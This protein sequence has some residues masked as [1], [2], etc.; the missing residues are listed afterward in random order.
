[1][2]RDDVLALV[3]GERALVLGASVSGL[4]AARAL[5]AL[6]A[7]VVLADDSDEVRNRLR[8][9]G[10]RVVRPEDVAGSRFAL[11]VVSPGIRPARV[12]ALGLKGP[13]VGELELGYRLTTTPITAVTGTNGK[14]TVATLT[15][16]MLGSG[17]RAVGNLGTALCDVATEPLSRLVVEVSSFQLVWTETFRAPVAGVLNI[18]PNH[19]D[20][21]GSFDAYRDAKGL[22]VA[23]LRPGDTYVRLLDDPVLDAIAVPFGVEVRTFGLGRG[24]DYRV[25]EGVLIGP[26]GRA[27]CAVDELA[28]R[29]EH[30]VL[31]VLAAWALAEASGANL[32]EARRAALAF[33]GLP[34]RLELVAERDGVR[35]VDDSKATTPEA[36]VAAIRSYPRVVLIAGGRTKGTGFELLRSVAERL[37]GLIAIGEAAP[38]VVSALADLVPTVYRADSMAEAVSLASAVARPG[39]VVLLAPGA[40]SWDWYEDFAA[41]GDDFARCVRELGGHRE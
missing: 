7:T 8:I 32:D 39:S 13:I 9:R 38:L 36:A 34:H 33:R 35:Y 5:E 25:D 23:R 11:S 10:Y 31:N 40:T 29:A 28:R 12:A 20:Y 19:L 3:R 16:A 1:M 6:G 17:V 30:E 22:L 15:A 41:R 27:L 18:T 14:S 21:H 26:E 37:E 2:S 24:A 4:A